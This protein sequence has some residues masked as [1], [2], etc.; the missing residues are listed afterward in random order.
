[1]FGPLDPQT[2]II[3]AL[4]VVVML[5]IAFPIHE[6]AH[7][8]AA[9]RLGD[10]TAKLMGRLTLDP[11]AHFDQM[12]GLLLAVTVLL[13]TIGFGWAKPTP[14]NPRNLQ[15]GRWG[16][17]IVS[18]AGPISNLV[19]AIAGALPLRYI[20]ATH[21]DAGLVSSFLEFF[22][23]INL[24]LMVFNLI[25]IPPLDGSKVLFAFLNPRTVWQ[26]RPV[27]EQYGFLILIGA[28]FLPIIGGQTIIGLVFN[29]LLFPLERLLVGG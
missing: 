6:F 20:N 16:E 9:Y 1:M 7:A 15:G 27:L 14:Y 28:M 2:L 18:A 22:V 3:R 23:R 4:V 29:E 25:P 19:L 12:G 13:T 10:G 17:A 5:G 24:V 26:V 11:R 8:L 21:M